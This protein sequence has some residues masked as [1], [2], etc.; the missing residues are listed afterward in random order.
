MSDGDENW[1]FSQTFLMT[2]G[3]PLMLIEPKICWCCKMTLTIFKYFPMESPYLEQI[4][5]VACSLTQCFTEPM[6]N[7]GPYP[8]HLSQANKILQH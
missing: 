8:T 7:R 4:K 5:Q 6:T 2:L 1:D 3:D